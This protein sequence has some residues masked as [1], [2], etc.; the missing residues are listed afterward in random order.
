MSSTTGRVVDSD[1]NGQVVGGRTPRK[2]REIHPW[3]FT[4]RDSIVA[5]HMACP[6]LC[7]TSPQTQTHPQYLT[8]SFSGFGEF[9]FIFWNRG[10]YI[11]LHSKMASLGTPYSRQLYYTHPNIYI[12]SIN[13][14]REP[15]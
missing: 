1:A 8:T 2:A 14:D 11:L 13:N 9:E 4:N 5:P 6:S 12:C 3:L 15:L 7:T 10:R